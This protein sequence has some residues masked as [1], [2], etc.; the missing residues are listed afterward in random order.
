MR[1]TKTEETIYG[2][3]DGFAS[4]QQLLFI[5]CFREVGAI[6][7]WLHFTPPRFF[8]WEITGDPFARQ[9]S[10]SASVRSIC[11][12]F[13]PWLMPRSIVILDNTKIHMCCEL[14]EV[15]HTCGVVLEYLPPYSSQLNPIEKGFG[16]LKH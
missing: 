10:H 5:S 15:V 11:S 13:Q 6:R 3:T 9:K 1:A 12:F 8:A 4:T 14:E 7:F 16:L 2:H